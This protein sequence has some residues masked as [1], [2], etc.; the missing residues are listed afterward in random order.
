MLAL[1]GPRAG[2]C[3]VDETMADVGA[4]EGTR[5]EVQHQWDLGGGEESD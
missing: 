5:F 2:K 1:V 3:E 4:A